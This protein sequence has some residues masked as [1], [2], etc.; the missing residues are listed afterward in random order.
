MMADQ[1]IKVSRLPRTGARTTIEAPRLRPRPTVELFRYAH[2]IALLVVTPDASAG[3]RKELCQAA[4][5]M[6]VNTAIN[7]H[8]RWDPGK[9]SRATFPEPGPTQHTQTFG[10]NTNAKLNFQK[11][12]NARTCKAEIYATP[13]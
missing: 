9:E 5:D 13:N 8:L 4:H 10:I 12:I 7:G 2:D 6:L 11:H 1:C 3:Q